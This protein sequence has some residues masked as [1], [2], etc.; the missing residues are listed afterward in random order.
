VVVSVFGRKYFQFF[1]LS[2]IKISFKNTADVTIFHS[3][4]ILLIFFFFI[5]GCSCFEYFVFSLVLFLLLLL[6]FVFVFFF[7]DNVMSIFD[8]CM[9]FLSLAFH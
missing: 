1:I 2:R 3:F 7:S 6:L 8:L 4:T 9:I 5:F